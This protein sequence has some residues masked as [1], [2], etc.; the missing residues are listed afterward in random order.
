M[1]KKRLVG[2]D[3]GTKRIGLAVADPLRMFARP[4]GTFSREGLQGALEEIE[5][6]DGIDTL[7]VGY[8]LSFGG[9]TNAM[10]GVIDRF[11][12]ELREAFADVAIE[13]VDEYHSSREAVHILA[14]AGGSRKDRKKKG[15]LDTAAACVLLTRYLEERSG[16]L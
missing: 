4:V 10:T 6:Q 8:P 15:R 1:E 7:V 2:L 16:S 5:R 3:Y 14:A 13:K 11:I 9:E 12:A